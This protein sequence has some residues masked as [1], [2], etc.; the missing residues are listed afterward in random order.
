MVVCWCKPKTK[1]K[2]GSAQGFTPHSSSGA[3]KRPGFELNLRSGTDLQVA[4][5]VNHNCIRRL[6]KVGL[7]ADR[8]QKGYRQGPGKSDV[9]VPNVSNA[10]SVRSKP[11]Q[12]EVRDAT[13]FNVNG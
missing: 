9:H 8:T 4:Q 3:A 10:T 12:K 11:N 2:S 6:Q 1:P 13:G 7:R 5:P